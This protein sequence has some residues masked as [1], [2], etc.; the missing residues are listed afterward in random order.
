MEEW[1]N[2]EPEDQTEQTLRTYRDTLD[3]LLKGK[4]TEST[5]ASLLGVCF[6]YQLIG[7]ARF[8]DENGNVSYKAYLETLTD[9]E[10]REYEAIPDE[11]G[12]E[13]AIKMENRESPITVELSPGKSF[14]L[15]PTFE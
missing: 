2:K 5:K 3:Q 7:L 8:Q 6:K 10:I 4:E 12:K 9:P 13:F 14:G 11:E 15:K 1:W